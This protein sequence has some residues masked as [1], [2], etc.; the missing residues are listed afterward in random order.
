MSNVDKVKLLLTDF[1]NSIPKIIYYENFAEKP[2]HIIS[3]FSEDYSGLSLDEESAAL[4]QKALSLMQ[5]D[6]LSYE[7]AVIKLS[8]R[9]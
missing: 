6:N 4:H 8:K 3:S 9:Q 7:A 5:K 1:L 2:E